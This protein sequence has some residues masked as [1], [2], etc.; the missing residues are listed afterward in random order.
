MNNVDNFFKIISFFTECLLYF[1][2]SFPLNKER[3]IALKSLRGDIWAPYSPDCNPC[4]FFLLGY[5]KGK[6]Y[7][8]VSSNIT[9]LKRNIK[10]EYE[11]I[12]EVIV[13]KAIQN[14]KKRGDS[15]FVLREDSLREESSN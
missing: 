4:D 11:R 7:N 12:P 2:E 5:L 1:Q 3:M 9:T 13:I 15:W 14:M 6:V 8:P 10:T